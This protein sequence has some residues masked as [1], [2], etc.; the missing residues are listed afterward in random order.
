MQNENV[1][2]RVFE[3]DS[4]LDLSGGFGLSRRGQKRNGIKTQFYI[5]TIYTC[6]PKSRIH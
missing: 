2:T 3:G 5:A 6:V 4:R 1:N